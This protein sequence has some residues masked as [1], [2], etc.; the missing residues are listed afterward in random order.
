LEIDDKAFCQVEAKVTFNFSAFPASSE[1]RV[2][3][4]YLCDANK[5][6][7]VVEDYVDGGETMTLQPNTGC[8]I[9][10]ATDDSGAVFM[11]VEKIGGAHSGAAYTI[12]IEP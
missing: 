4:Y 12:T 11:S 3:A 7:A 8:T 9:L 5:K 6:L 10:S 1:F 2:K